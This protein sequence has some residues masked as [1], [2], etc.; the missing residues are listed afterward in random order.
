MNHSSIA[1][2]LLL[3]ATTAAGLLP[4]QALLAAPVDTVNRAGPMVFDRLRQ[5]AVM[6]HQRRRLVAFDGNGW[7]P[8]HPPIELPAAGY[9]LTY[10]SARDRIAALDQSNAGGDTPLW[11]VQGS[12]VTLGPSVPAVNGAPHTL[13]RAIAHDRARGE[14][15]VFGGAWYYHSQQTSWQFMPFDATFVL[16]GSAWQQINLAVRPPA[17]YAHVLVDDPVRQRV[18]MF[19][20]FGNAGAL[21]DCWEWNGS[22]WTHVPA[23]SGPAGGSATGTFDEASQRV[24]IVDFNRAPWA[25]NGTSWT[26][27]GGAFAPYVISVWPVS[28]RTGLLA[29]VDPA[30]VAPTMTTW[31]LV[32]N[33][34]MQAAPAA[35]PLDF[36]VRV[37]MTWDAARGELLC[38][39][40]G[41]VARTWTWNGS[42]TERPAVT[43]GTLGNYLEDSLAFDAARNEAVLWRGANGSEVWTWNGQLW[44]RRNPAALPPARSR[45]QIVYDPTRQR[46]V[47]FGGWDQTGYVASTWLWDGTT[48]SADPGPQPPPGVPSVF[49]FDA[50]R[51]AIVL[52][53]TGYGPATWE[54]NGQWVMRSAT[55]GITAAARAAFDP[56]RGRLI[57][58]HGAVQY[59]WDGT[60]WSTTPTQIPGLQLGELVTDPS[61][62]RVWM[63]GVT[64]GQGCML[65][66]LGTTPSTV[67]TLGGSCGPRLDF[68]LEGRSGVGRTCN[69]V[70]AIEPNG[71][72]LFGAAWQAVAAPFGPCTLLVDGS[73]GIHLRAADPHGRVELPVAIPNDLSLRG[74]SFVVQVAT[75]QSGVLG[76]SRALRIR[77]G[78]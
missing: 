12:T 59:E 23:A 45:G 25:W 21:A 66:V 33:S 51:D 18:V 57:A 75:L 52:S 61:R 29:V 71:W 16:R 65:H 69:L 63:T 76:L 49:A 17:R 39:V 62:N 47:L 34:W 28:D 48:W 55:G 74:Y 32:G 13:L 68:T 9:A 67:D 41:A 31:R 70:A 7:V 37:P 8:I 36:Q 22:A 14:F 4:A 3:T 15:V 58:L 19:G 38:I 30:F 20:G 43:P 10:D 73:L 27:L 5:R 72:S 60:Q 2:F 6:V 42:W 24:V 11:F 64:G 1:A 77:I 56:A 40:V 50:Y 78:D 26:A 54:W 44:T 46:V 35:P 53:G